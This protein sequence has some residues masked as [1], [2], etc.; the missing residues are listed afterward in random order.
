MPNSKRF[1]EQIEKKFVSWAQTVEDIRAAFIVGSRARNDHPAD[2]WSDMDII[3]YTSKQ[4]YYLSNNKWLNNIGDICTSFVSQTGGGE[5]EYLTLFNG[6]WQVDFVIHSLDNLGYIVKNKITPNNFYR[7]VKVL[8]DKD[9]IAND[10][11]PKYNRAPQGNPLSE[12]KFLQSINMFW[13]V[14]LYTAKQIL[15][16][17]L[18][19]V[20]VRDGN[21]KQLLLQMIEWH[22]KAING[23][24]YDTWH[25]GRFL[26]EWANKETQIEL[27]NSFGHFDRIDSWKALMATINLFKRLSHEISR[28]MNF[29]YPYDLEKSVYDWIEQKSECI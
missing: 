26:C 3:F 7:G 25:A 1:Y 19:M 12:D 20:K 23:N 11:I 24:E 15:R 16:N 27:Q 22:E 5:P 13:F 17:E 21:M 4:N 2:E 18:W 9:H 14:A 10:I 6:G 8:I 29:S 28:I